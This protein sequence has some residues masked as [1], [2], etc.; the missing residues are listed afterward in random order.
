MRA[1]AK[2]APPL[3]M[4]SMACSS[5]FSI[6]SAGTSAMRASAS[7]GGRNFTATRT[8][9][10]PAVVL[11]KSRRLVMPRRYT[12]ISWFAIAPVGGVPQLIRGC[13]LLES[14]GDEILHERLRRLLNAV[15]V[16]DEEHLRVRLRQHAHHRL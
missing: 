14:P 13:A 2:S 10:A 12:Q 6:S 15:H 16:A 7:A 1:S 4:T 5:S 11:R 8:P 9:A 3:F